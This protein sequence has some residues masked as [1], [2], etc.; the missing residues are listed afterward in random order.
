MYKTIKTLI[1]NYNLTLP[2]KI[3]LLFLMLIPFMLNA[4][5]SSKN[6]VMLPVYNQSTE[7]NSLLRAT[8]P[9]SS[10][11]HYDDVENFDSWGFFTSGEKYDV[12][13]KWNPLSLTDYEGWVITKI[14]FIVVNPLPYLKAKVWEGP[15][16]SII[17]SQDIDEFNVNSWT[18]VILDTPVEI[19]ITKPLYAGYEVD[20]RHTEL[21]GAVS[22]TDDGPSVDG[23]G[24]IYRWNGNWYSIALNWN[25]WVLIEYALVADFEA[26][27][28]TT[29]AGT[30][31]SYTN[32]SYYTVD[33]YYWTFEGGTPSSST[34]ENPTV[35]YNSPGEYDVTLEVTQGG[36]TDSEYR[37]N[38]I[39]ALEIPGQIEGEPMVCDW[40]EEE[41]SVPENEGSIYTWEV[42][43][44]TIINGQGTDIV[45]I[46]WMGE[47]TGDVLVME[48]T[49]FNCD[50]TSELFE[51][52]IDNCTGITSNFAENQ[53]II[54]PNPVSGNELIL[55]TGA[56]SVMNI[57]IFNLNGHSIHEQLLYPES[58]S[59]NIEH[60]SKGLYFIK[61]TFADQTEKVTKFI[62]N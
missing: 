58:T 22:A 6:E 60:L 42:T 55:Y 21:G 48:E 59:I 27:K 52:T 4:Q 26:D 34:Q 32:N 39:K 51:V 5:N 14:K 1:M 44:G 18:E 46:S 31:V 2:K 37:P 61:T 62:R 17:Y 29:C 50:G 28:T 57:E 54:S 23:F 35:T 43:N 7:N 8:N 53:I 45:T 20:M 13:A 38:Y 30:S 25:L 49:A 19:D 40:S 10:W 36:N 12:M 3:Y 9:D 16:A 56:L 41:Y 24:N 15:N 11:M 33:S 47:G